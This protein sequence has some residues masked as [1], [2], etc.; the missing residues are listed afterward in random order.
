MKKLNLSAIDQNVYNLQE[1]RKW[2]SGYRM[3]NWC[4]LTIF[5]L[6]YAEAN[7]GA[8]EAF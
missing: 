2:Y 6:N 5:M 7:C 4:S 1:I 8:F 3:H